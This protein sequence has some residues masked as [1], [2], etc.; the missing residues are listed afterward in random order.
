[1][2]DFAFSENGKCCASFISDTLHVVPDTVG[3]VQLSLTAAYPPCFPP[4]ATGRKLEVPPP[5]APETLVTQSLHIVATNNAI[6]ITA[7]CLEM[8]DV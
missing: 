8:S 1:M 5:P 3:R 6:T 2:L 4:G 7:F